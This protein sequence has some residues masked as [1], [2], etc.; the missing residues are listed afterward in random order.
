MTHNE[1][2]QIMAQ[3]GEGCMSWR[4]LL[5]DELARVG[6]WRCGVGLLVDASA[7]GDDAN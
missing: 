3:G 2:Q 7:Q 1:Y 6:G 4:P 5:E